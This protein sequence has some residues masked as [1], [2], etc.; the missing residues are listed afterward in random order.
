MRRGRPLLDYL[1]YLDSGLEATIMFRGSGSRPP[2]T[3]SQWIP[4]Q[5]EAGMRR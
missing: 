5:A 1:V 3:A 2:S 4:P